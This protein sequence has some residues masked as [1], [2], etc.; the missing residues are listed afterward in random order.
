MDSFLWQI[1]DIAVFWF[2]YFAAVWLKNTTDTL[3]QGGFSSPVVPGECDSFLC[4]HS[5]REVLKDDS[6]TKFNVQ[7][8]DGKHFAD[9]FCQKF[10]D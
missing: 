10:D 8:L 2:D 9:G 4:M 6:R 5:E 1:P 7:V 3:H